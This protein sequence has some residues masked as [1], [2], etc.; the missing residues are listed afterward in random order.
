MKNPE[1]AAQIFLQ[2]RRGG[3][4]RIGVPEFLKNFTRGAVDFCKRRPDAVLKTLGVLLM[5]GIL[6]DFISFS[7]GSLPATPSAIQVSGNRRVTEDQVRTE[8]FRKLRAENAENL[9]EV[10]LR[11]L[12]DYVCR[13]IP[14]IRSNRI[15]LNVG[16]GV[17]AVAVEERI[18]VGV[19][20]TPT[21]FLEFDKEGMLYPAAM[22][23]TAGRGRL[24]V[25]GLS[26]ASVAPGRNLSEHPS[27][28]GLLRV[29]QSL[30]PGLDRNLFLIRVIQPDYLELVLETSDSRRSGGDT[31]VLVKVDPATF[32]ARAD[33]LAK[34][35]RRSNERAVSYIDFRF[36]Q[37][38]IA[39][40][41]E[42]AQRLKTAGRKR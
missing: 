3:K 16:R 35:V 32:P 36:R 18:G 2:R 30:P 1:N 26:G 33:Q 19:V 23:Q 15:T 12:S 37:A 25:W 39:Y 20:K 24:Q 5:A 13:K 22:S 9:I 38:V 31:N 11:E 10:D 34:M 42:T 4:S 7:F 14:G 28:A 27:G 8:I 41:P 21:V 29:I 40:A 6:F 17:M